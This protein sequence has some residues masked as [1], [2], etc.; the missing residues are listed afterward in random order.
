MSMVSVII[1][2]YNVES[3]LNRCIYSVVNQTYH[4]LEII[5]IDD[6]S[7][8]RSREICEL[9][10]K[11]DKRIK[12]I[13]SENHGVS[14][15]RN[16]GLKMATGEYISF[17]DADDWIDMDWYEKLVRCL[18]KSR[19]DICFG[20]FIK[21]NGKKSYVPFLKQNPCIYNRKRAV[22]EIYSNNVPGI[23]TKYMSWELC[24]KIFK[25]SILNGLYF[26]EK[27]YVGEDMLLLWQ[28]LNRI[29]NVAYLPLFGYHY[30]T[31]IGSAV[32][33]GVNAKSLTALRVRKKMWDSSQNEC[34]EIKNVIRNQYLTTGITYVRDMIELNAGYYKNEI[35][36]FQ[37]F[38]RKN[39]FYTVQIKNISLKKRIGFIFFCLP[40]FLCRILSSFL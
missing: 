2:V 16:I 7:T 33:S 12:F 30:F 6:G 14:Y 9:W 24:D 40:Y 21:E 28:I 13:H 37:K 19:A 20:G 27:I 10:T 18:E 3:Y 15:A 39:I 38:L 29:N 1:P 25:K 11:K 26:D 35:K 22:C 34:K 4:K 36:E 23:A 31:R 5:I 17:L 32:Q 8:D